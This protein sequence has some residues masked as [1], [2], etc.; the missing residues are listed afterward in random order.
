MVLSACQPALGNVDEVD[1]VY[2]LQR[3]LKKA[4]AQSIVMSLWRVP[5]EATALLMTAFYEALTQGLSA[6]H[7]LRQARTRLQ[8]SHP[9]PYSW[10]AFVVL[11][12]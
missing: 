7:A 12:K 6:T 1:G 9:D 10:A 5:D 11:E 2:G 8:Q 3:G 4:G